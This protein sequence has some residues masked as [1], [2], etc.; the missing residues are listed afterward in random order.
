M[1]AQSDKYRHEILGDKIRALYGHT[2]L[3]KFR[4]FESIAIPPF[5]LFHGTSYKA[6]E[7]ILKEGLKPMKRQYVHL[8][9][10]I[11]TALRVAQRKSSKQEILQIEAL[12][13]YQCSNVNF[14]SANQ[15]IWLSDYIPP[16]FIQVVQ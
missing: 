3:G 2:I 11:E 6:K 15:N 14:Y 4:E 13:A 8:S 12:K 5:T 1:T 9:V 7:I 16:E 10:D